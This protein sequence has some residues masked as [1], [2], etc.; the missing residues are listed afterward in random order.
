MRKLLRANFS[1]L[2]HD[3]TFWLL[4]ALMVF[5]GASMAVINAVNISRE[6]TVWVMDFSLLTYV[7][8]APILNSILVALFVGSDYF[9]GTLRNKLI[10]GHR[11]GHI[12]LANLLTCCCTGII[13]CLTFVIPQG[14][15]GLLLGGQIRSTPTKLLMYGSLSLA[16]MVAFT[17][18]FTLIAMLC[19]NKS[20]TVAGCVLLAFILIFLGV[21]ITSALNESEYLAGYS[22]TENGVTVEEPEAKNPNYISGTKRQVYEFMQDFTPGGQVLQISDM[23]TEKPVM[24]A[25]YDGIILLAATGFGM[26]FFRRKDLK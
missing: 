15:L 2:W 24:L 22:Y 6:G 13:L 3:R 25:L 9:G 5:F 11:R 18:L 23:D 12:Y 14:V 7:T 17:A 20:H 19:Q 10:A 16:L 8:L 4:T 1:R 21:Y 26:A